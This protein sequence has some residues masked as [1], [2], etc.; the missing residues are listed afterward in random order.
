M[1]D[2]EQA[3]GSTNSIFKS[4]IKRLEQRCF[5]K[6]EALRDSLDAQGIDTS[7]LQC[8]NDTLNQNE[9]VS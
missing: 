8:F 4:Q 1:K 6:E 9:G 3:G 5:Q 7:Q 2:L